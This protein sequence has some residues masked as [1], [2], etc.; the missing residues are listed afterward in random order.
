[1]GKTIGYILIAAAVVVTLLTAG[2]MFTNE[3]L[4]SSAAFLG[5]ALVTLLVALPLGGAGVFFVV[6]GGREAQDSAEIAQ[7]RKLLNMIKTQGQLPISDAVLDLNTTQ[8]GVHEMLYSLVGKGIFSGYV[9]WDEGMLYSEQASQLREHDKCRNCGGDLDLA[10]K[11]VVRCP[12]CGTE[13]F[14]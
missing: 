1:M 11:G 7:E 2:W 8:E 9:N 5:F 4:S 10:G 14:L 12:Y 3:G 6:Q 13:Y